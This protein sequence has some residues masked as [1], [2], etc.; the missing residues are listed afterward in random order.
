M[1]DD[2]AS[3]LAALNQSLGAATQEAAMAAATVIEA[4][5]RARAPVNTGAL[6]ASL[7]NKS[8]RRQAQAS[9][10]I[11]VE[12]SG[13]DGTEHYAIFQEYGTSNMPAHPFMRPGFE[14]AQQTAIDAAAAA[15]SNHLKEFV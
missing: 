9:A 13:P 12:H 7:D 10:T 15:L 6:V 14:A 11:Q 8:A 3:Q 4:E 1:A 5:V 2:L